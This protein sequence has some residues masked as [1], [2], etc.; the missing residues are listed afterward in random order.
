M[1]TIYLRMKKYDEAMHYYMVADSILEQG[2][3]TNPDQ[4]KTLYV[5][6]LNNIGMLY[7]RMENWE[8]AEK[9]Y[10]KA[11]A[12]CR[13]YE[14]LNP[15]T[16]TYYLGIQFQDHSHYSILRQNETRLFSIYLAP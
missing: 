1:G 14:K 6:S 9:Y 3:Q 10:L 2:M 15:E 7:R 16:Y 4:H 12:I 11:A 13:Q 5:I 8:S